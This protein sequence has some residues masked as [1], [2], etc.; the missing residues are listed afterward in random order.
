MANILIIDDSALSRRIMRRI[1]EVAGYQ[2][3]EAADGMAGLESYFLS[4]PDLVL[5]D[6]TMTGMH[7]LEALTQLRALDS[8]ARVIMASADI[9]ASTRAMAAEAGAIGFVNKPLTAEQVLSAVHA[10]LQAS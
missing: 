5:L 1:L 4:K 6:I 7:G 8:Q 3:Q 10:A 9:Q 2:V